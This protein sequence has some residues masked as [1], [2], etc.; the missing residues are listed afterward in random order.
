MVAI[1]G[2]ESGFVHYKPD[3]GILRGRVD[4]RDSGLA[5]INTYYHP[6]VDVDDFWANLS[7]ARQLFDAQGT[8]PWVCRDHVAQI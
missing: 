6:D 4:S 8:V 5:Q 7:Y 3:G 1:I 2:C